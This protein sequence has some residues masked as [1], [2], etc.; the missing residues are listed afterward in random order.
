LLWYSHCLKMASVTPED[1]C[2]LTKPTD[3]I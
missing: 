1:V 2:S 3:G